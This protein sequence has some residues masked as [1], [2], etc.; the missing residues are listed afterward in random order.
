M[1]APLARF[2]LTPGDILQAKLDGR[3]VLEAMNRDFGTWFRR[4]ELA[5]AE[6][7]KELHGFL[8]GRMDAS[9]IHELLSLIGER[10]ERA[11]DYLDDPALALEEFWEEELSR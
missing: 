7:C 11:S 1:S 10:D 5:A 6:R 4:G 9:A 3:N 2:K 8:F